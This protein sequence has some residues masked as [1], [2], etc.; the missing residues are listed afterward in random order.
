M[1][2]KTFKVQ[3]TIETRDAE[4]FDMMVN[5]L[6]REHAAKNVEVIRRM[7]VPGHC[8][9]IQWD[10]HVDK[11]E[12]KA[13]ELKLMGVDLFCGDCPHFHLPEDKRIK[14]IP[15]HESGELVRSSYGRTACN[16]YCE[17]Y[18]DKIMQK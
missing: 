8:A 5:E 7:D 12:G 2:R 14:Y 9:Y 18:Y 17:Q 15:C 4:S 16:W 13:D 11:A 10:E 6:V 3:K 1:I